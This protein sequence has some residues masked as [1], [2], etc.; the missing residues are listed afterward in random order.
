MN[1]DCYYCFDCKK[2]FSEPCDRPNGY[3]TCKKCGKMNVIELM[4]D[5][6]GTLCFEQQ[7]ELCIN[8]GDLKRTKRYFKIM[9]KLI[10]TSSIKDAKLELNPAHF[11]DCGKYLGHRGFCSDKCHNKHYDYD[12]ESVQKTN[13]GIMAKQNG[14]M[15][16]VE[17]DTHNLNKTNG[18]DTNG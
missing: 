8:V 6:D 12:S 16:E 5:N 4:Y 3:L 11:C 18:G 1:K 17:L 14:K 13:S 7:D 15:S 9:Q 2:Y 10:D